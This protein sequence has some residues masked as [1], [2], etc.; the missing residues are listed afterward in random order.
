MPP[1]ASDPARPRPRRCSEHRARPIC[2]DSSMLTRFSGVGTLVLTATTAT[3]GLFLLTGVGP[4]A[5]TDVATPGGGPPPRP[6]PPRPTLTVDDT[7]ITTSTTRPAPRPDHDQHHDDQHHDD[8]RPRRSRCSVSASDTVV[9]AG[10]TVTFDGT[11]AVGGD[12]PLGPVIVWVIGD[13]DR[14]R[15]HRGHLGGLELHLDGTDSRGGRRFL[16][17]PVLVRRPDRIRSGVPRRPAAARRHGGHRHTADHDRTR[18]VGVGRAGDPRNGLIDRDTD[19]VA[20]RVD[21]DAAHGS[22]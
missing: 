14:R 9:G 18:R 21:A 7:A 17:L 6:R 16:H 8:S 13:D 19:R 3:C 1:A 11:C 4:T 10:G 5:T 2:Q 15:R 22:A 12:G 20:P